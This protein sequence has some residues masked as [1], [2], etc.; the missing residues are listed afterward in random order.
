MKYPNF[1]EI[2]Q[3]LFE[4]NVVSFQIRQ[5]VDRLMFYAWY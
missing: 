1:I 3:L 2:I 5:S 4:E